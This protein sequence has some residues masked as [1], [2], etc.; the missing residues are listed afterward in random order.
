MGHYVT[1]GTANVQ[2]LWP[3]VNTSVIQSVHH[4]RII[5]EELHV[6]V[7]ADVWT[8]NRVEV[9]FKQK[10]QRRMAACCHKLKAT[11]QQMRRLEKNKKEVLLHNA[12]MIGSDICRRTK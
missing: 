8:Q 9:S 5:S 11:V 12:V 2:G 1:A 10:E 7:G 6:I 4:Q 3:R